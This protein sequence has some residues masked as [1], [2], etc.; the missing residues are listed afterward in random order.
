MLLVQWRDLSRIHLPQ[1]LP[2]DEVCNCPLKATIA[3]TLSDVSEHRDLNTNLG[4]VTN[5]RGGGTMIVRD[6]S[7]LKDWRS[8]QCVVCC[9]Q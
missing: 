9:R 3:R 8:Q 6:V 2:V 7:R 4:R 5:G 1:I